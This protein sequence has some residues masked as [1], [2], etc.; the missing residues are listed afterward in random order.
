M[1]LWQHSKPFPPHLLPQKLLTQ[2]YQFQ[3]EFSLIR[4][5]SISSAC[6]FTSRTSTPPWLPL[7]HVIVTVINWIQI[8]HLSLF[9]ANFVGES[10]RIRISLLASSSNISREK[11]ECANPYNVHVD[12]SIEVWCITHRWVQHLLISIKHFHESNFPSNNI[13]FLLLLCHLLSDYLFTL[14]HTLKKQISLAINMLN[15]AR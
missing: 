13:I 14:W 3:R 8:V 1:S 5:L 10:I 7:K 2:G 11:N 9:L 6:V 15:D 12:F 4:N